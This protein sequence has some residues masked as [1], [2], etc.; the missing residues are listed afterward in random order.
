MTLSLSLG[1]PGKKGF[2]TSVDD[3]DSDPSTVDLRII[4]NNGSPYFKG[5][6]WSISKIFLSKDTQ[7]QNPDPYQHDLY[8][9]FS[10][11][12]DLGWEL[13]IIRHDKIA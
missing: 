13:E 12:P 2:L 10:G 6:Y 7:G 8:S 4:W 9:V 11:V 3:P 5:F 1:F